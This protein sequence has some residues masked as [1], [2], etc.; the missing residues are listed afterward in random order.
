MIEPLWI[1]GYGSLMWKP[2]FDYAERH[3]AELQGF[4]RSF[5]M[6][7]IEH[8]GTPEAP[9]LVLA[10]EDHEDASCLGVAFRAEAESAEAT[11]AYLRA[12]ELVTSAYLETTQPVRLATGA[13][14]TAVTYVMDREHEQYAGDLSHDAQA[15][16]IAGA[17]GGMGPNPDY[18]FGT[19]EALRAQKIADHELEDIARRVAG[20]IG[21]TFS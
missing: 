20:R 14:V 2:G 17:S 1:F 15:E 9:G 19:V 13:I 18:L 16:I 12:R 11:L 3:V 8:R 7:S 5:C 4:R 21:S 6:R 10:L